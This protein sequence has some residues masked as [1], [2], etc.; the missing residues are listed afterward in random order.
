M[1]KERKW[2]H[3]YDMHSGGGSKEEWEHI[4][5]EAPEKEAKI[6]FFNRFG[7]NANRVSCTCCG[8]DYSISEHDSLEQATA[9]ERHCKYAYFDK[10]GKEISQDEAWISGK[11]F[12]DGAYED[13]VE[14]EDTKEI[15][16]MEK[17][18]PDSDW[19]K[20]RKF[21]PLKD[22]VKNKN[23]LII[24]SKDIKPKERKGEV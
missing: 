22:Y 5:I 4:F 1:K 24:Y 14:E 2:T 19:K 17:K 13:Y 16:E 3:F 20:Y 10:D 11:G 12:I 15:E 6:I 9:F 8:N 21:I 18:Y 23:V 7:H